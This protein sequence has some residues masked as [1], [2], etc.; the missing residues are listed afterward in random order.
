MCSWK[1]T[2]T[3]SFWGEGVGGF[4]SLIKP[5]HANC[6]SSLQSPARGSGGQRGCLA[7]RH[8][9]NDDDRVPVFKTVSPV[10]SRQCVTAR[11]GDSVVST[12]QAQ[13]EK[14]ADKVP[15]PRR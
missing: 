8:R 5:L 12:S 7:Q 2:R 13:A 3:G 14:Q 4:S 6:D 1:P 11:Q 9:S 15:V 10:L